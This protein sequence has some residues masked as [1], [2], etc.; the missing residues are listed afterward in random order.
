MDR[1]LRMGNRMDKSIDGQGLGFRLGC[2]M[3]ILGLR[4]L[5]VEGLRSRSTHSVTDF[6]LANMQASK[7]P[8]VAGKSTTLSP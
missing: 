2:G 1:A 4:G 6:E 8:R 5:W 7:C 3:R